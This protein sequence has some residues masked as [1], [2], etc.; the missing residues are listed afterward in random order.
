M[1]N[2]EVYHTYVLS[3]SRR[4]MLKITHVFALVVL[5][6]YTECLLQDENS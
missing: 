3:I 2:I 5:V 4:E 1:I 6:V